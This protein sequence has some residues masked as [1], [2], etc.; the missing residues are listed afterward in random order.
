MIDI[1]RMGRRWVVL[2][3]AAAMAAGFYLYQFPLKSYITQQKLY[4]LL[5]E[6]G[7]AKEDIQIQKVL[8]DYKSARSG[9]V[10][11]F[12][13]KESPLD[14]QYDYSFKINNWM[15]GYVSEGTIYS[16]DKIIFNENGE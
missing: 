13:V 15:R 2:G 6:E 12:T 1:K 16:S 14:Y 8:K 11:Y 5:A 7:V 4:E 9:Y 10:M 3:L